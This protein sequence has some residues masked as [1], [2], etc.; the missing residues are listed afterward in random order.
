MADRR[1]CRS[2]AAVAACTMTG[3]LRRS[4][5]HLAG[6]AT[7]AAC[8]PRWRPHTEEIRAVAFDL[9]TVFDPRE[10]QRRAAA[11]V[12]RDAEAFAATWSSRLFEYAWLRAAAGRY[13]PFDELVVDALTYAAAA[14]DLTLVPATADALASVFTELTPWPDARASLERLRGRGLRLAPLANFSPRM[15]DR[16]LS[17]AG[18]DDLFD[19]Q[20]STEEARTY[21]PDPHAYAIAERRFDLPRASIAFAAFGGWDAAGAAWFGMPTFW[22][23]RLGAPGEALGAPTATGPDLDHLCAWLVT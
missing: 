22:V 5:L 21:K 15:I 20:I 9:F 14:H 12:A 13:A 7:L 11:L 6:T 3:M 10:I 4:W 19:V 17:R 16:L 18:L 8:V 1:R 2:R 23:N